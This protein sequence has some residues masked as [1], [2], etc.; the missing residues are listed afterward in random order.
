MVFVVGALVGVLV[1]D[2]LVVDALAVGVL[3]EEHADIVA[4]DTAVPVANKIII[5]LVKF[6]LF[7]S[8]Y[9]NT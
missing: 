6:I 8:K 5:H 1:V 9:I 7:I 2:V 3:V 4:V